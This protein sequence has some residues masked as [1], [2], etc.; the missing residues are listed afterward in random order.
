[1]T[2]IKLIESNRGKIEYSE[3]ELTRM[4]KE[5]RKLIEHL[6]DLILNADNDAVLKGF[7]SCVFPENPTLEDL[8]RRTP[9]VSLLVQ[10]KDQLEESNIAWHA[11]QGLSRTLLNE[12]ERWRKL[13]SDLEY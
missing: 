8:Q 3:E 9:K 13:F 10:F 12:M 2:Q 6:D 11:K 1:M 7:W 4:V 5:V